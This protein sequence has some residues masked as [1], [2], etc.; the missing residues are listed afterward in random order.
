MLRIAA[1]SLLLLPATAGAQTVLERTVAEGRRLQVEER[2]VSDLVV[3]M[4]ARGA[5]VGNAERSE[6]VR[7]YTQETRTAQPEVLFRH[8]E[9]SLRDKRHPQAEPAPER[10][11]LHGRDVLVAGL[12]MG[13][14]PAGSFAISEDDKNA[15][16]FD[17]VVHVLL[18]EQRVAERRDS[19]T[20]DSETI[21]RALFGDSI[22]AASYDCGARVSLRS[23]SRQD[24]REVAVLR[25]RPLT[26]RLLRSEHLPE[27]DAQLSGEI[28]WS[29]TD[30]ELLSAELEG[31][32]RYVVHSDQGQAEAEGSYRWSYS[33]EILEAG[34]SAGGGGDAA[35]ER[36]DPPPQGTQ[37]L[38]CR[39]EASHVYAIN[40]IVRCIQCGNELDAE[41]RCA[42]GHPWAFQY[43]PRDGAALDPR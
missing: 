23:V 28:T 13:P 14:S 27:L 6:V 7:V 15:L 35:R 39:L 26:I 41:K 5:R 19:W 29:V 34:G 16:R 33:A 43:C 2:R 8:Y 9:Q 17:R 12:E 20:V 11:S 42:E 22:A 32:I 10:T 40:E 21:G 31:P 37:A 18:P 38:V 24:G 4:A 1:L 30:G 3:A 25:V 36:G